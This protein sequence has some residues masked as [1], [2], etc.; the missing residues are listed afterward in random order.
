MWFGQSPSSL[1][2]RVAVRSLAALVVSAVFFSVIVRPAGSAAPAAI[3]G[4]VFSG[5]PEKPLVTITGRGLT[6]PQPNPANSPS[7]QRLCPKAIKGKAGFDYGTSL[8]LTAFSD[9][10][11]SFAA[12]RYRPTRNELDCVG[13]IVLSHTPTQIRLTF[14]AAYNQPDFGYPQIKS[15]DLVE[16]IDQAAAYGLVVQYH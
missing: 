2:R 11:L 5:S 14:G 4:V 16:V 15:G 12:G 1:R 3:S 6:V 9:D 7:N 8:Y 13:I 10:K